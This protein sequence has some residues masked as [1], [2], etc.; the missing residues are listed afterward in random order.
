MQI[1]PDSTPTYH[2]TPKGHQDREKQY[3]ELDLISQLNVNADSA[4]GKFQE[5]FSAIRPIEHRMPNNGAQ[6]HLPHSTFNSKYKQQIRYADSAPALLDHM[7]NKYDWTVETTDKIDW[8][9]H[10]QAIHRSFDQ[11]THNTKFVHDIL[12]TNHRVHRYDKTR[13][14]KCPLCKHLDEDRDHILRCPEATRRRWRAELLNALSTK[15][16]NLRTRLILTVILLDGISKWLKGGTL[17]QY[18]YKLRYH[19]LIQEQNDIG[20]RH[21]CNG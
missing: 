12:P 3:H 20:W 21:I 19:Q 17:S 7:R 18:R 5:K 13:S 4:A 8:T 1:A 15:C 16:D 9:A 10:G 11:K 6:L 14:A 2:P